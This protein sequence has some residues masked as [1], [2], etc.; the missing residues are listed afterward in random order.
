MIYSASPTPGRPLQPS[1][2][3]G[4]GRWEGLSLGSR[5][6]RWVSEKQSTE[7]NNSFSL[8]LL[9][10][11]HFSQTLT[12]KTSI[13][14]YFRVISFQP[15]IMMFVHIQVLFLMI[16]SRPSQPKESCMARVKPQYKESTMTKKRVKWHLGWEHQG[17]G[18]VSK[19][20]TCLAVLT[21]L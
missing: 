14:N 10:P 12:K 8:S 9:I 18:W 3:G 7:R 11:C 5:Q 13:I 20:V 4:I 17:V 16:S 15:E 21:L 6:S 2:D 1:P 19:R